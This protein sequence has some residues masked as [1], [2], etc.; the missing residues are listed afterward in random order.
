MASIYL[1]TAIELAWITHNPVHWFVIEDSDLL[2]K[3]ST[4]L[5]WDS[6][7][8]RSMAHYP[9]VNV[10]EELVIINTEATLKKKLD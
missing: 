7:H 9:T 6:G 5:V 3:Y 8:T 4:V 10:S 1:Q 2:A